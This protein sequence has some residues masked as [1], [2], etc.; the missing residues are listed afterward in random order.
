MRCFQDVKPFDGELLTASDLIVFVARSNDRDFVDHV[1]FI[2][3]S[4]MKTYCGQNVSK[5]ICIL[6]HADTGKY[7]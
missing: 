2:D 3:R 6:I 1:D 4:A 7:I 5:K